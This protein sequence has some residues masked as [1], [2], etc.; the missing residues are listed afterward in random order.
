MYEGVYNYIPEENRVCRVY[1][2]A[3]ILWLEFMEM[4]YYFP[5][6]VFCYYYYFYYYYYLLSYNWDRDGTVIKVLCFKSEGR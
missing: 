1:V 5:R 2:V 6:Q 3:A 4:S